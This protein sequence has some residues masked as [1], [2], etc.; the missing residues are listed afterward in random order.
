[1]EIKTLRKKFVNSSLINKTCLKCKKTYPRTKE[2]FYAFKHHSI[3]GAV[4]FESWCISCKQENSKKWKSKNKARIREKQI[5]YRET[6]QGHFRELWN[7]VRKSVYGNKFK[8]YEE[9]FQC[10]V[11]QQKIYGTKCPYSGIEMTRTRNKE[12]NINNDGIKTRKRTY[13]QTNISKDRI[14]SSRPYSKENIMFV[15]W[16]INDE[17][18]CIS[19][20]TAKRYLEIVKERFGTD[21]IE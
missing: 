18:G 14:L 16:A 5:Q 17:K 10:W 12:S 6:E 11:E 20:K 7:G 2:F 4:N 21:D 8:N 13:N 19:P 1:M 15:S 3:K 9:F